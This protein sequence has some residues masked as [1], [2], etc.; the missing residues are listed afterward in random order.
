MKNKDLQYVKK[1]C[2]LDAPDMNL[3]FQMP[4]LTTTVPSFWLFPAGHQ[5]R[6]K[7]IL[8]CFQLAI[9]TD[10]NIYCYVTGWP[11]EPIQTYIVMCPVVRTDDKHLTTTAPGWPS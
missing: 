3:L 9:R 2:S 6:Y 5:N 7:H 10:T 11:S 1:G 4:V 8:F